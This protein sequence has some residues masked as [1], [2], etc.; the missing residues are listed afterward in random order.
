MHDPDPRI[1][2]PT[3]PSSA[4]AASG[5]LS[6]EVPATP[7]S[8]MLV[9]REAEFNGDGRGNGNSLAVVREEACRRSHL[10]MLANKEVSRRS[11]D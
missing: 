5:S 11:G 7:S 2:R 4:A 3:V 8:R 6:A 9:S 10:Q 1:Y